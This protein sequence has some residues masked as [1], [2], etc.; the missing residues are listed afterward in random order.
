MGTSTNLTSL[1]LMTAIS[2]TVLPLK[3]E[4]YDKIT[5]SLEAK[6]NFQNSDSH[7]GYNSNITSY[8]TNQREDSEKLNIII[9]FSKELT[10]NSQELDS[11][12]AEIV[13]KNFWDLL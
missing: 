9:K 5:P 2:S 1:V 12:F 4:D 3:Y 8:D 13:N 7:W 10:Q 6:Y 11:E